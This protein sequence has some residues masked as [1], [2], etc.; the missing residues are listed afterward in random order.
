V[1][2]Q[3]NALLPGVIKQTKNAHFFIETHLN[4]MNIAC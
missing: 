4:E 1:E 3:L 2:N